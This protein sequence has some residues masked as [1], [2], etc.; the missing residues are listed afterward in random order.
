[1][2]E[3]TGVKVSVSSDAVLPDYTDDSPSR[4]FR[5]D[6]TREVRWEQVILEISLK[7]GYTGLAL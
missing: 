1:M 7:E 4:S 6:H 5:E 3:M 2:E